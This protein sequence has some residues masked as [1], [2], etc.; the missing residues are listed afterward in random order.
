MRALDNFAWGGMFIAV[1][2]ESH[3]KARTGIYYSVSSVRLTRRTFRMA[4]PRSVGPTTR[5]Q[6]TYIRRDTQRS[7]EVRR[8]RSQ[9]LGSPHCQLV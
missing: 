7:E 5:V 6:D 2:E 1:V 4:V 8:V 3:E 9:P